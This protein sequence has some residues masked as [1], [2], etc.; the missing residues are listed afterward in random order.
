MII[1]SLVFVISVGLLLTP[2]SSESSIDS[3]GEGADDSCRDE[4][5]E[6]AN[7][8]AIL[9]DGIEDEENASLTLGTESDTVT[10]AEPLSSSED[11]SAQIADSSLFWFLDLEINSGSVYWEDILSFLENAT[12]EAVPP[13][14]LPLVSSE[15]ASLTDEDDTVWAF[16]DLVNCSP[17]WI[18]NF[19][20]SSDT[21]NV[22][23]RLPNSFSD[24]GDFEPLGNSLFSI[25]LDEVTV[26]T[27]VDT[28]RTSLSFRDIEILSIEGISWSF[29]LLNLYGLLEEY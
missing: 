10:S 4:T 5:G 7:D 2:F 15:T 27:N 9:L 3:E 16:V 19:D 17:I 14:V 21:I 29:P 22:V 24:I 6:C 20:P 12:S 25:D 13:N 8:I 23:L 18:D 28:D 26:S 1:L 11:Q